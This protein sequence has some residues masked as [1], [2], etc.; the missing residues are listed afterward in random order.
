M[1]RDIK[2][3]GAVDFKKSIDLVKDKRIEPAFMGSSIKQIEDTYTDP[4]GQYS[5][6]NLDP[7]MPNVGG[8]D[9]DDETINE[10]IGGK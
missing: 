7:I 10:I 2:E 4:R 6:T 8:S 9:V 1:T 3:I 5:P